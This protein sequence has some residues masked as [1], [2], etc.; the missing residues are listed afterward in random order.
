LCYALEESGALFT[1]DH[2]MGWSTSVVVPPDGDMADYMASLARLY[3][4]RTGSIT[5]PRPGGRTTAPAGARMI[6]H[7]KQRE[8]QIV[9]LLGEKPHTVMEWSRACTRASMS[10]SG[11]PR[12]I[13]S[14][15]S[16]RA[17]TA[18]PRGAARRELGARTD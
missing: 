3:D 8:R 12:A 2:V 15:P 13:R 5:R 11:P 14:R 18:G 6:G 17:G 16:D 7:R 10:A 4:A 9:K 1:G